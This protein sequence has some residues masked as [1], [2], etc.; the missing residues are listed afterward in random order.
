MRCALDIN[1]GLKVID[2]RCALFDD[3]LKV[4]EFDVYLELFKSE[5]NNCV[6]MFLHAQLFNSSIV[7]SFSLVKL[8]HFRPCC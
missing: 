2:E 8:L 1:V 4:V 7:A 5:S 3:A 6:Q